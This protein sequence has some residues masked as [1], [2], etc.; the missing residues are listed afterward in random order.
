LLIALHYEFVFDEVEGFLLW[1]N[2]ILELMR[3]PISGLIINYRR[4]NLGGE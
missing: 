3:V 2:A 4:L 1:L